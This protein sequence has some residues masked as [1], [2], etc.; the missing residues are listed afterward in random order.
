MSFYSD[1]ILADSPIRY[2]RLGEPSGTTANDASGNNQNGT[3]HGGITLAQPGLLTSDADTAML[4]NGTSGYVSFPDAG[5]P[6]GNAAWTLECWLNISSS[7]N[8]PEPI[9]YGTP[10]V[11][12][13]NNNKAA[14][15]WV[16]TDTGGSINVGFAHAGNVRGPVLTLNTR[17]HVVGTF[18]GSTL[19]L[20][21]DGTLVGFASTTG[22]IVLSGGV[23]GTDETLTFGWVAGVV[24]E[25][26]IYNVALSSTRVFTHYSAGIA[27]TAPLPGYKVTL[28]G[29]D[30]TLFIDQQTIEIEDT[31]GQGSGAGSSGGTTVPTL[32]RQ[33]EI[34]V[35]D[36]SGVI[37]F[38]GFATKYTDTTTSVIGNTK[39]NFTAIEGVDYST[40][41][42][43]TIVNETFVGQTDIQIIQFVMQKYAP[44]INLAFLPAANSFIFPVKN[45]RNV[46]V[47][48]V[49]QTIAGITGFIVYV[50]YQ[51]FLRYV[52]PSSASSAPFGLSDQPDFVMTFPHS[53]T[54][55]LID[56]NSI[57]NRVFFYGGTRT[58]NDFTQD[59]STL[60]NGNNT[61][62]PLAYHPLV[63]SDGLYHV[64]VN[65][66]EKTVGKA[67]ATGP[68]NTLKSAGGLAD[69]LI[70]QSADIATFDIA[71]AGGGT[72]LVRYRYSFPLSLVV[73][74]EASHKFF[75]GYYDGSISDN[76]IFDVNTA[77]QRSKVLLSQQ[78]FGLV[79][80]KINTYQAGIQSGML[81]K[82][83]NVVRGIN[84]TYL[85]QN[86]T[87]DPYGSG[88]FVFRLTLGAWD[89]NLIDFLLKLPTIVQQDLNQDE[90]QEFVVLQQLLANVQ[91]HDAWSKT[92]TTPGGYCAHASVL[93]DGHD[94]YPGFAT[95]T[96]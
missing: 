53:V 20:Y 21:L 19:R 86:V 85:V 11:T 10:W 83:V 35:T 41:L 62:F 57:I 33:G 7:A 54:E 75:G 74:D 50:D 66:T 91:V 31:L 63:T 8:Y 48:Q 65:G 64:I 17:H 96:T 38:G 16:D 68:A 5:L 73:T 88:K 32:V 95:I 79:T 47:E 3:L 12:S 24:D 9:Q 59:V 71:P 78:A 42:Q 93:G 94:A 25:V 76:T 90:V 87:I 13:A 72:V 70:D 18:D 1:T 37:I 26:A 29:Q 14:A 92:V 51:K 49:L 58:S 43:R 4:F 81:I 39:Q 22:N 52:S 84:A 45:F 55:F 46:S 77:I 44:W 89:W 40:S 61:T 60:A 56:D 36:A 23:I 28:A 82:V 15:I 69:V 27:P 30:I 6:S 80:L 2:Y 67:N 34:V